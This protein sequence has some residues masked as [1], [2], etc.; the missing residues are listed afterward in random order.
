MSTVGKPARPPHTFTHLRGG[1][2]EAEA[3]RY[4][5]LIVTSFD[6]WAEMKLDMETLFWGGVLLAT[7][8]FLNTMIYKW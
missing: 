8:I 6:S 5:L 1:R 7:H 4:I 2:A 3:E